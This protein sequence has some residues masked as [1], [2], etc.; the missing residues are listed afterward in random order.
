M[1]NF[2][3]LRNTIFLTLAFI[4]FTFANC[5]NGEDV[6]LSLDGSSLNYDSSENIGGFQ[7][8]HDGCASGA[9]GGDAAANGFTVSATANTVLAFSF[10]GSSIPVGQGTLVDLGSSDCTEASLTNFVFSSTAGT[11]LTFAWSEVASGCTDSTACNYDPDAE[12]NDGSCEYVEDCLGECGGSAV[13]DD[14][15]DCNGNNA[16]QD[17]A[18]VCDGDAVVDCNG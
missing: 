7:F 11:Q 6:C 15:G 3:T 17:C 13:V 12:Q 16:A 1:K 9:G 14:C 2:N 5:P 8:N 10:T 18:G 4:G